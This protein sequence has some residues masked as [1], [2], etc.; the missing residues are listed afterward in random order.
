MRRQQ[1]E[2][3]LDEGECC[4]FSAHQPARAS[5]QRPR[6][7]RVGVGLS[8]S[9][10]QDR[11]GLEPAFIWGMAAY[12]LGE[13]AYL[14]L[15]RPTQGQTWQDGVR[16]DELARNIRAA[17]DWPL[18]KDQVTMIETAMGPLWGP[19]LLGAVAAIIVLAPTH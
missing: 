17:K 8:K 13:L 4:I 18:L 16:G 2:L 12:T 1:G 3:C 11:L 9:E 5:G 19:A 14:S 7:A 6:A 10:I 15:E